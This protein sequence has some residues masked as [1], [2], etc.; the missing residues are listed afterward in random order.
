MNQDKY[1][2]Y[3]MLSFRYTNHDHN[4]DLFKLTEKIYY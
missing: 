2:Q 4:Q 3:L 1:R